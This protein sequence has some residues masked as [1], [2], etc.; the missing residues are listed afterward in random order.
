MQEY[1]V[2][3]LERVQ[4]IELEM[5][6][7][8]D[9]VCEE[10]GLTYC[11]DGG[12]C[13]GA[14]RH[15]GFIPWDDD[16]DLGMPMED[17]LRLAQI[18][19]QVLPEG[20]SFHYYGNS[21]GFVPLFG[22][23]YKDGTRFVE[24]DFAAAGVDEC[25]FIDIFPYIQ[26]EEGKKGI[27]RLNKSQT[28]QKMLYLMANPQPTVLQT[29]KP[30]WLFSAG[31]YVAHGLLKVC[32]SRKR[33]QKRYDRLC[34]TDAQTGIWANPTASRPF[35]FANGIMFPPSRILF[36]GVEVNA[37]GSPHDFLRIV[38]GEDYMT[39]PPP[40]KRHTHAPCLL[41]FGDG[42]NAMEGD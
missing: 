42:V 9:K 20:I 12:T 33:L 6:V 39:P 38:F 19:D 31:M 24:E 34:Q 10:H 32:T 3:A 8:F 4:A 25:I 30:R 18:A 16:I 35:P 27:R 21:E 5:L 22:K 14:V 26:I 28:A 37:P 41:D 2:G 40:N 7:A 15:G 1:P 23:L 11:L 17:F 29:L 13:L 36:E